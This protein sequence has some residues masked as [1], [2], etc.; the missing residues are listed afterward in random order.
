MIPYYERQESR[1][2]LA[3]MHRRF[4]FPPH[5]HSHLE[6]AICQAGCVEVTIDAQT[7]TLYPGDI[8]LSCPHTVHSYRSD[9]DATME[10]MLILF[11]PLWLPGQG[12]ALHTA[13]A[14]TPFIRAEHLHPD[15]AY[16]I[17][18]L[19]REC[20]QPRPDD[21]ASRA[22]MSLLLARVTPQLSLRPQDTHDGGGLMH[23]ALSYLSDCYAQPVTLD[24]AA[25]AL[26]VNPH[27]LS[28]LFSARLGMGFHAYVNAL[29]LNQAEML[30]RDSDRPITEICYD[31]GFD[32]QRTFNR[33]FKNAHGVTP[34]AF[35]KGG[36]S[37]GAD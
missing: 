15:V 32:S 22:L 4:H 20:R 30:L 2:R 31:C 33:V 1:I 29:R 3:V 14:A 28:H 25:Q 37:A 17:D 27:H 11:D 18:A 26:H 23:R 24:S 8:S 34:R 35:R 19:I 36:V 16:A 12:H 21:E 6:L 9:D 10:G 7:R 13:R 5:L